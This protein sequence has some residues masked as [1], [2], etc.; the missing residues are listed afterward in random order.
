MPYDESLA[1]RIRAALGVDPAVT[2]KRMFGG[3]A[4]LHRGLM[5][6]GVAGDSLMA[7]VGVSLRGMSVVEVPGARGTENER[8]SHTG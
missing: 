8:A 7:R 1:A 6:A 4:F 2:E 3:I 5:F